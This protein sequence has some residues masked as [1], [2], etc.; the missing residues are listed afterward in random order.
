MYS[1]RPGLSIVGQHPVFARRVAG[2]SCRL[3]TSQHRRAAQCLK[4]LRCLGRARSSRPSSTPSDHGIQ[5]TRRFPCRLQ[6]PYRLLVRTVD[7][8][9]SNTRLEP[10]AMGSAVRKGAPMLSDKS[11]PLD[12][13]MGG[14]TTPCIGHKTHGSGK[15]PSSTSNISTDRTI[16]REGMVDVSEHKK[17]ARLRSVVAIHPTISSDEVSIKQ[18]VTR[19]G[20]L[21]TAYQARYSQH[22]LSGLNAIAWDSPDSSEFMC[23]GSV[24]PKAKITTLTVFALKLSLGPVSKPDQVEAPRAR[25]STLVLSLL[26]P[27]GWPPPPAG[28]PRPRCRPR[29]IQAHHR[30]GAVVDCVKKGRVRAKRHRPKA[31]GTGDGTGD[32]HRFN[33]KRLSEKPAL[34]S[35]ECRSHTRRP[36]QQTTSRENPASS[37]RLAVTPTRR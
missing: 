23:M 31:N 3:V 37:T 28:A 29:F 19:L 5:A 15:S 12:R 18:S 22:A 7:H 4:D 26:G 20:H 30:L 13:S 17:Q 33:F 36:M 8:D 14:L 11:Q 6:K 34:E 25:V 16:K 9:V 2:D 24:D 10:T 27:S 21:Q 32:K 1:N 35:P